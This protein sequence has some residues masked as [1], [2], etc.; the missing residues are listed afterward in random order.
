MPKAIRLA[1]RRRNFYHTLSPEAGKK[2]HGLAQRITMSQ[3][4]PH[5]ANGA[6][7]LNWR[8]EIALTEGTLRNMVA[9]GFSSARFF[10][11]RFLH[12]GRAG[13]GHSG[14]HV[15]VVPPPGPK[16]HPHGR[17]QVSPMVQ[18]LPHATIACVPVFNWCRDNALAERAA[19]SIAMSI[20]F[21]AI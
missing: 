17:L 2:K 19:A 3:E 15:P 8:T 5:A 13:A 21:L 18:K 16:Q 12:F 4:L 20:S 7:V 1:R 14:W 11:F 10:F 9:K 6:A